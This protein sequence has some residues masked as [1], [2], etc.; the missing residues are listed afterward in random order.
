MPV[1]KKW[2]ALA[3]CPGTAAHSRRDCNTSSSVTLVAGLL[4]TK[5]LSPTC[6]RI[7][8]PMRVRWNPWPILKACLALAILTAVGWQFGRDL[9]RPE[10]WERPWHLGWLILSG[11][12][13]VL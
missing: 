7:G 5:T 2:S 8:E 6:C 4:P 12:C 1:I 9:R 3:D 13:Y 10:L 11:V